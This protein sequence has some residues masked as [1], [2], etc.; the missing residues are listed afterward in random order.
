MLSHSS[1]KAL[2]TSTLKGTNNHTFHFHIHFIQCQRQTDI[3]NGG[4]CYTSLRHTNC[5][6]EMSMLEFG[7]SAHTVPWAFKNGEFWQI[8]M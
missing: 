3:N 1:K 2:L 5:T 6:N 8:C 7:E 4:Q